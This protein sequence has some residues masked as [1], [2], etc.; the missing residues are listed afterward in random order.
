[1]TRDEGGEFTQCTG[2]SFSLAREGGKGPL[3]SSVQN[4]ENC[5]Q[6]KYSLLVP[7]ASSVFGSPAGPALPAPPP[8]SAARLYPIIAMGFTNNAAADDAD[9]DD[10]EEEEEEEEEEEREKEKRE[11]REKREK[12]EKVGGA[13]RGASASLAPGK[14]IPS[15]SIVS[16]HRKHPLARLK[17]SAESSS[18]PTALTR[19]ER[20]EPAWIV[21]QRNGRARD[22]ARCEIEPSS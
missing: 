12:G 7:L 11:E 18:H 13:R 6:V 10:D 20:R 3:Y 16:I 9:D 15:L 21:L 4:S 19:S 2:I 1:M 5:R 8:L 22:A 14:M 17:A